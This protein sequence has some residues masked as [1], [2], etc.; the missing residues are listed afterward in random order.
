MRIN[1]DNFIKHIKNRNEKA[2]DYMIDSYGA[3]VKSIVNKNLGDMKEYHEECMQDVFLDV[4]YGIDKYHSE[5]GEF[6][7]WIGAIAKYKCIMYKRKYSVL[8]LNKD[9][10]E[11]NAC[12]DNIEVELKK[13]VLKDEI[14]DLLKNLK[15]ED[16]KIFIKYYIEEKTVKEISS[17]MNIKNENIYNRLSRGKKKLRMIFQNK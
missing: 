7:N 3:L 2:L 12:I 9:L 11:V 16:R 14:D 5:K 4:W 1:E 10:E 6:K 15:D 13:Q 8:R 17:D